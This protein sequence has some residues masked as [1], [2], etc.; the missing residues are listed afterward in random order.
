MSD[1]VLYR[2]SVVRRETPN[3]DAEFID[4][5]ERQPPRS[6]TGAW[7]HFRKYIPPG[8]ELVGYGLAVQPNTTVFGREPPEAPGVPTTGFDP[9]VFD[10]LPE[11]PTAT[12][13]SEAGRLIALL[14]ILA[15][16][17][18]QKDS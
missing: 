6:L 17:R 1:L 14:D 3:A 12:E 15:K 9:Q 8:Y 10:D 5:W 4:V 2:L 13:L 11:Q 18:K 7:D 16:V